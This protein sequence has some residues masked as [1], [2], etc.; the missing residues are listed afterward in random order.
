MQI[1]PQNRAGTGG[2]GTGTARDPYAVGDVE[3]ITDAV[4]D[5]SNTWVDGDLTAY[6]SPAL[7]NAAAPPADPDGQ[8]ASVLVGTADVATMDEFDMRDSTGSA[9]RYRYSRRNDG[10]SGWTRI[11][12]G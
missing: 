1:G 2:I 12:K 10:T 8:H 9:W 6:G 7:Q 11:P 5:S 3:S 4:L